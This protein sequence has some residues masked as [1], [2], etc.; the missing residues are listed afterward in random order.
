LLV[1]GGTGRVGRQLLQQAQ[2]RGHVVTALVRSP[3]KLANLGSNVEVVRGNALDPD[4]VR[5]VL[6]GHE[7]VISALGAPGLGRSTVQQDAAR[8]LVEAM[9]QGPVKRLLMV[10]AGM[11]FKDAGI[12]AAI[13]RN[14]ILRNVARDCLEADALVTASTLDWTIVR[15]PRLTNG[16]P[17]GKYAAADGHLPAGGAGSVSRADVARFLLDE[18]ERRE[19]VRQIVGVSAM[20]A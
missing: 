1:L 9:R 3:E 16:A 18:V 8:A 15:P 14:T 5:A 10:S 6:P 12:L 13:I 2:E 4:Q 20:A 19:H 7:A 11:L 17:T